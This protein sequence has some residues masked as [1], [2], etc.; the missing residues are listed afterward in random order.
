MA[1]G[2]RTSLPTALWNCDHCGGIAWMPATHTLCA[3]E[4]PVQEEVRSV[5]P[6]QHNRRFL[7]GIALLIAAAMAVGSL[8]SA[9]AAQRQPNVVIILADDQGYAD[10]GTFG[11]EGFATPNLDRMANEGMRFRSFYASEAVCSASRASLLT[12]CYAPRVSI[13]GALMPWSTVGLNP[14]EVTIAEIL[15][16]KG[17]ATGIFGKWHLGHHREFLPLQQG[18]DEYFGL[19][20]SND[21]WP[22]GYDGATGKKTSY[23]PL[24][25]IE[26]NAAVGEVSSLEDQNRLTTMYTERAVKFIEKNKGRPFF[27]YV[28]HSMPHVPLGVSA[29]FRGK[30]KQGLYG[31]VIMEI[32]W[33]VGE[34]LS[35]LKKFGLD[36][37]TLVIFAS[38]NGPWLNF[39]NHAGSAGPLRE[40]KGT[41]WEGGVRV[42]CIMRW[43]GRIPKGTSCDSIAATIDLL[44]TIAAI[45]GAPLPKKP[46]DGVNI[47]P[48]LEGKNNANPRG[49]F[50]YYYEG[51]LQAARMGRW[52]LHFPHTYRLYAG[53]PPG[54]DGQPGL[55]GS[56]KTGVEL[57]DLMNDIGE[58]QNMADQNPDMVTGIRVL[59]EQARME[60]GDR[61][62]GVAGGGVRPPGRAGSEQK[63]TVQNLAGGKTISVK[64]NYS[65]RYQGH[66]DGT[67]ID[68]TRGSLDHAD[69]MWLGFEKV[70]LEATINLGMAATL[71]RITLGCMENQPSWIFLPSTVE[72]AVSGDGLTYDVIERTQT[73]SGSF[74]PV[75]H[76]RD[77]VANVP[78][79]ATVKYIRVIARNIG[80]CPAWHPGA[81]GKAWM[82]ADEIVVE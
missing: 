70:D 41:A 79:G 72:F 6:K 74:D 57:Y 22:R 24:P 49:N 12:G 34:I 2:L 5:K 76:V 29:K 46:I 61:I 37:H 69:G 42:P 44:P 1:A 9:A 81:G 40:G 75:P 16:K 26:G 31:D 36:E 56:G 66:G 27:L 14:D 18:F 32:D 55:T 43:P 58:R 51:E 23:P 19:P 28:P 47:L 71:R 52:K 77:F 64:N 62:T 63:R 35:A 7:Y 21:M 39:G 11:A 13:Q 82:F 48:L 38:D 50:L 54:N 53:F 3:E 30:S 67:L 25:L 45:T 33:S 78:A 4:L 60:L 80:T 17:Y 10:V 20:Y 65:T 15:K 73:T 68:G 8:A 59:G